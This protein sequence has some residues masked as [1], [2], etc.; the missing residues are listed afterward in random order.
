MNDINSYSLDLNLNLRSNADSVLTDASNVLEN[1]QSQLANV[2]KYFGSTLNN[3]ALSIADSLKATSRS[4]NAAAASVSSMAPGINDASDASDTM[5][6]SYINMQDSLKNILNH[7]SD[8][9]DSTTQQ[10]NDVKD[11]LDSHERTLDTVHETK[12]LIDDMTDSLG[13]QIKSL[14]SLILGMAGLR[15]AWSMLIDEEERFVTVNYRLYGSQLDIISQ[16]GETSNEFGLMRD[17]AL[18]AYEVLGT[19]L[20]VP[21]EELAKYVV[22]VV[23]F[24]RLTGTSVRLTSDFVRNLKYMGM[25]SKDTESILNNLTYAMEKYGLSGQEIESAITKQQESLGRATF[26]WGKNSIKSYLEVDTQLRSMAYGLPAVQE[27]LS[28]ALINPMSDAGILLGAAGKRAN[29]FAAA[30]KGL[31]GPALRAKTVQLGLLQTYKELEEATRGVTDEQQ[32]AV[33][34]DVRLQQ[35]GMT[36]NAAR[37]ETIALMER[38]REAGVDAADSLSLSNDKLMTKLANGSLS[39]RYEHSLMSISG[40]WNVLTSKIYDHWMEVVTTLGPVFIYFINNVLTPIVDVVGTV[41]HVLTAVFKAF[42]IVLSPVFTLIEAVSSLFKGFWSVVNDAFKPFLE[43]IN[44]VYHAVFGNTQNTKVLSDTMFVLGKIIGWFVTAV[45]QPF[46]MVA[47]ILSYFLKKVNDEGSTLGKIIMFV[48]NPLAG[49]FNVIAGVINE[50]YKWFELLNKEGTLA[51]KVL[52]FL[53]FVVLSVIN[54]FYQ[55]VD[56]LKYVVSWFGASGAGLIEEAQWAAQALQLLFYPLSVVE[57]LIGSVA[58]ALKMI[59]GAFELFINSA[60][61]SSNTIEALL[62]NGAK[63]ALFGTSILAG[64]SLIGLAGTAL[65]VSGPVLAVGLGILAAGLWLINTDRINTIAASLL[66]LGAGLNT[67]SNSSTTNDL[68]DTIQNVRDSIESTIDYA[69]SSITTM[70]SFTVSNLLYVDNIVKS[71][72]QNA[73]TLTGYL[74]TSAIGIVGSLPLVGASLIL[75]SVQ[76]S[77]ASDSVELVAL[78]VRSSMGSVALAVID[79]SDEISDA[80]NTKGSGIIAAAGLLNDI[81]ARAIGVASGNNADLAQ[82]IMSANA[83]VSDVLDIIAVSDSKMVDSARNAN[84]SVNNVLGVIA[85]SNSTLVDTARNANDGVSD[86]LNNSTNVDPFSDAAESLMGDA[87]N[88]M[89]VMPRLTAIYDMI[90]NIIQEGMDK[91]EYQ[92]NRAWNILE[93]IQ[94]MASGLGVSATDVINVDKKFEKPV[95]AE[96]INKS[97]LFTDE[98]SSEIEE[99]NDSRYKTQYLELLRSID[100][101]MNKL[102]VDKVDFT[103]IVALLKEWLPKVGKEESKLSNSLGNWSS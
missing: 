99:K 103:E 100:G 36:S 8:I 73:L 71:I 61:K 81:S 80:I 87:D 68:S 4:A 47:E 12:D 33:Q 65:A 42:M 35:A 69:L 98:D 31:A 26:L 19:R 92:S 56:A 75:A 63:F 21:R 30:T 15:K 13:T 64:A 16:V 23:E 3:S 57:R 45:L 89:T 95:I 53:K 7:H 48:L 1:I 11:I 46:V 24:N 6:N 70:R 28:D 43:V 10:S 20:R 5:S 94:A 97:Q 14:G 32:R 59:V 17:K 37:S 62:L 29:E 88:L 60:S 34:M 86:A 101:K 51:N 52:G 91:I 84:A 54:P 44:Q 40:S 77:V 50:V 85:A 96:T 72:M 18:E 41:V 79:G 25:T 27:A 83:S 22:Q 93:P 55:L 58:S 2:S 49:V 39:D 74:A 9:S 78:R 76:L 82:S 102:D 66:H 90:A 38:M 67:L